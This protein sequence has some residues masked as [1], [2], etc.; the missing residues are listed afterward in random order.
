MALIMVTTGSSKL[1]TAVL[2]LRTHALTCPA[3][4][5]AIYCATALMKSDVMRFFFFVPLL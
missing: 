5:Q 3:A 4:L 2:T 1:V